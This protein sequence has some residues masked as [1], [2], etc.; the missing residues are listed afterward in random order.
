M[1]AAALLF[2][3]RWGS[4]TPSYSLCSLSTLSAAAASALV[5]RGAVQLPPKSQRVSPPTRVEVCLALPLGFSPLR[6]EKEEEEEAA[7]VLVES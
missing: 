1:A 5:C 2:L 3:L 4:G 6:M 7:A